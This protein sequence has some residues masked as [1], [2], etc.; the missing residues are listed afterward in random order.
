V[1]IGIGSLVYAFRMM[2]SGTVMSTGVGSAI[3]G[4]LSLGDFDQDGDVEVVVPT[5][6]GVV[7]LIQE[8]GSPFPGSWPVTAAA[9][10]INGAAIASCLG[11]S[12]PEIAVS[13]LGLRV[14]VLFEDGDVASG[15]PVNTDG[16][17]V[18]GMPVI[19]EVEGSNDIIIGAR[20]SKA[21]SWNNFGQVNAG[22][23][24][25]VGNHIYQ[26]PAYGDLDQDGSA[27]VVFLT[28]DQLLVVDVNNSPS[29]GYRLWGM[30]GHDHERSGCAD[31]AV[32]VVA[33]EDAPAG[34][35]R[36]SMAAPWPNPIAG[37]ATFAYAVPI[38]ARV[39]LAV[40]DVRGRRVATVHRAEEPAGQ[41]VIGWSGRDDQGR[42]VASGQYV[43]AL[44]VQGPGVD[45]T[46]S[47]KV[48]VLR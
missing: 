40:Y 32:D 13:A 21:W 20:G 24:K 16:W 11:T 22:W 26:T 33:V 6:D 10:A 19:G 31:C 15:F 42:P 4:P 17:N 30:A 43:A 39:E 47:R 18:Y 3:S 35:T 7:H 9:Q 5:E 46:V 48:T 2:E 34:V 23:P 1:V 37:Q 45:E 44:R 29:S 27:E 14:S 28:L 38:R 36:V 8:D 25:A 12:V 41:H